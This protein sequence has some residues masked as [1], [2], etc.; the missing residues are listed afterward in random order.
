M[1]GQRTKI[2]DLYDALKK[3]GAVSKSRE[4]FNSKM[5][6]PG[7]EGYKNR[8]Q[9]YNALKEDGAIE[10]ETYEEFASKLGLHAV[11]K[12]AAKDDG[13]QTATASPSDQQQSKPQNNTQSAAKAGG[14]QNAKQSAQQSVPSQYVTPSKDPKETAQRLLTN[15][16]PQASRNN[17][18]QQKN[19]M[20]L[21]QR[22][23]LW[24]WQNITIPTTEAEYK[25]FMR[26]L[27]EEDKR[28]R[29]R[30]DPD[31]IEAFK[32][33]VND[34]NKEQI[35]IKK[36]GKVAVKT[37]N[38]SF[39]EGDGLEVRPFGYSKADFSKELQGQDYVLT[40]RTMAQAKPIYNL[41]YNVKDPEVR[42]DYEVLK[43]QGEGG[44]PYT[45][46]DYMIDAAPKDKAK[47]Y[48][49][50]AAYIYDQVGEIPDWVD[51]Q[52]ALRIRALDK[53][54]LDKDSKEFVRLAEETKDKRK[55]RGANNVADYYNNLFFLKNGDRRIGNG[56]SYA[57]IVS[58]DGSLQIVAVDVTGR[59][60]VADNRA[61]Y[62]NL[63]KQ[64]N[65]GLV[66]SG[67]PKVEMLP[68][69]RAYAVPD[70]TNEERYYANIPKWKDLS[71]AERAPYKDEV[72]YIYQMQ[73][74]QAKQ[75][76]YYVEPGQNVEV[77]AAKYAKRLA[78]DQ[79]KL[80]TD[81]E[82]MQAALKQ[83]KDTYKQLEDVQRSIFE[84]NQKFV[85]V[86]E[87][88]IVLSPAYYELKSLLERY[89][90][91]ID[92]APRYMEGRHYSAALQFWNGLTDIDGAT[93]GLAGLIDAANMNLVATN[94][95]KE[96]IE[97]FGSKKAAEKVIATAIAMKNKTE[98]F[99]TELGAYGE[100]HSLGA[101][102]Q[103]FMLSSTPLFRATD[104]VGGFVTRRT[105][106]FLG[107]LS[108]G[109][110]KLTP[111][112]TQSLAAE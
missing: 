52:D 76:V 59:P 37:G 41:E 38:R 79:Y 4:Y 12:G 28:V 96:L 50:Y 58:G 100:S 14:Q 108:K 77:E 18:T 26:R 89:K 60:T 73:R 6:A 23:K 84:K 51:Y 45:V 103:F 13:T 3:D 5:L 65:E 109:L 102:M 2:D 74:G 29:D 71:D 85:H 82:K 16:P 95:P 1:S 83:A 92:V 17:P 106:R 10:S 86:G 9:L 7:E 36:G 80:L 105:A 81:K 94:P 22:K 21:E 66:G 55:V 104:A 75:G 62:N 33:F 97:K 49:L 34:L 40:V 101:L 31:E 69:G 39:G 43:W 46:T 54:Q 15:M 93:F 19:V 64:S 44:L 91:F 32:G 107:K 90:N 35:R 99:K 70:I 11:E 72:D 112:A 47:Y 30:N 110:G 63:F 98:E 20:P 27:K 8:L 68:T 67:K 111:K 53:S 56:V 88:G 48:N 24:T 25:T 42:K 61:A 57:P 78:Q 87:E